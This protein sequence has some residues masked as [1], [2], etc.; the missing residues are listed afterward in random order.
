MTDQLSIAGKNF[1]S[2]LM[3]GTGRHRS[4]EEMGNSIEASGAQIVTVAIGRLDLSNPSEK[5]ILDYFDWGSYTILPN[6]AGSKTAEEAILTARL[7][8]EVTGTNWVKL[9]VI[10]KPSHL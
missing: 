6:T 7:G 4:M 8:R 2:R 9:E 5:T 3:V 10:P 1:D